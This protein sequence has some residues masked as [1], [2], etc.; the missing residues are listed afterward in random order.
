[1]SK[2]MTAGELATRMAQLAPDTPVVGFVAGPDNLAGK[3]GFIPTQSDWQKIVEAFDEYSRIA[4]DGVWDAF[5]DAK[6]DVLS[7]FYCDEC[8]NYSYTCEDVGSFTIMCVDCTGNEVDNN[9]ILN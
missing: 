2:F 6:L 3:Y 4:F 9:T 8:E 7:G 5:A 1:M